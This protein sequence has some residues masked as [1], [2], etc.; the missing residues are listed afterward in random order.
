[1][2][3]C[4]TRLPSP[5][6][7]LPI[8]LSHL[9]V[10]DFNLSK[11]LDLNPQ[12]STAASTNPRQAGPCQLASQQGPCQTAAATVLGHARVPLLSWAATGKDSS[13]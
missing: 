7:I 13:Q 2:A 4:G 3:L 9:Q 10:A 12:A 11:A 1:V 6:H 8:S 5:S